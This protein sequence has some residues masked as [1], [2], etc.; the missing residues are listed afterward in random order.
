M[1]E[2][3]SFTNSLGIDISYFYYYYPNYQ[4]DKIVLFC[5][6][7]GPGHVSYLREIELLAE[8]GFKVLTLDYTGCG[9]SKGKNMRSLNQPTRDAMELLNLLQIKEEIILMGHSLGGYTA[10]NLLSLRDEIKKAVV[11]APFI[12]IESLLTAFLKKKFIVSRILKY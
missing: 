12:T 6:G 5:H 10:L 7:L 11:L 9:E 1:R 2:E 4:K 3:S 8:L